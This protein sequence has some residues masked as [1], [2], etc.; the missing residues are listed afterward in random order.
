MEVLTQQR[1][2][3][4]HQALVDRFHRELQDVCS[5]TN[6]S[7]RL[8]QG[9]VFPDGYG[10]DEVFTVFS[11]VADQCDK[12]VL[13]L[14]HS[15]Y[16]YEDTGTDSYA[17]EHFIRIIQGMKGNDPKHILSDGKKIDRAELILE[18]IIRASIPSRADGWKVSMSESCALENGPLRDR[19]FEGK[20]RSNPY[21]ILLN[22]NRMRVQK[23]LH[24]QS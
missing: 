5:E 1:V 15:R 19:F 12:L 17:K 13:W 14:Q 9:W 18:N 23:L 10:I 16:S 7:V 20:T 3:P 11:D 21:T 8:Q 6:L 4:V 2:F 24:P 22:E